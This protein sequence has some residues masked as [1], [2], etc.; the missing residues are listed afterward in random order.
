MGRAKLGR[1]IS[2]T[3]LQGLS[4]ASIGLVAQSCAHV[5]PLQPQQLTSLCL[6]LKPVMACTWCAFLI[7]ST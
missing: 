1:Y 3:Y 4:Q 7:V 5:E 6:P 2:C